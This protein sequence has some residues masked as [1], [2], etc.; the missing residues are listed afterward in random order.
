M[1]ALFSL[2]DSVR[3]SDVV[4]E[5]VV[6]I[7]LLVMLF[8]MWKL[9]RAYGRSKTWALSL[10]GLNFFS[11][12]AALD[13]LDEF[14]KMP[15][16]I[17]HVIEN[18]FICIGA[19]VFAF[20]MVLIVH[21]LM[22]M[23]NTDPMTGLYNKTYMRKMLDLEINR[24]SRYNL[25]FSLLFVD[26]DNFKEIN[27]QMGHS[28]GDVVLQKVVDCLKNNVRT[29]DVLFRYGGDEFVLLMPQTRME[30]SEVLFKRLQEAV[31]GLEL[32]GGCKIR[33]SGG[34][35]VFPDDG[36]SADKLLNMADKRMYKNKVGQNG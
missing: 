2:K 34:I 6:L 13:L 31:S 17:P 5:S 24:S 4:T 12:G 32:P 7:S 21:R 26:F 25:P 1:S 33:I 11:V 30:E 3:L 14:Y 9:Y 28:V 10:V 22:D 8:F 15:K 18:S 20:G 35:A 19:S 36:D 29:V 16:F 23:S 27:D